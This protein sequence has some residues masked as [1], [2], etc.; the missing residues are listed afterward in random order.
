ME[1]QFDA[2]KYAKEVGDDLIAAFD[3]AGNA[4]TPGLVGSAREHATRQK[5]GHLLP[6]SMA[7]GT[8][9]VIDSYGGV[10]KHM[11]IVLYEKYLCPVYSV[12]D[13]PNTTY[14]PCEGVMAVGEIKS[15]MGSLEMRD[16]FEKITSVKKLR[17]YARPTRIVLDEDLE[18][19]P[20]VTFRSY[21]S[22]DSMSGTE[23]EQFDQEGKT[24]DQIF[25][26][27]LTGRFTLSAATVCEKY[28]E[29][30]RE[31]GRTNSPNLIAALDG[32]QVVRPLRM[33]LDGKKAQ[34]VRG[35][36]EANVICCGTPPGNAFQFLLSTI[37]EAY[38][39]GRTVDEVAFDRYFAS[40]GQLEL[41][42][43]KD[44]IAKLE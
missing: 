33:S 44:G 34:I 29:F 35:A 24:R 13:D 18:M 23:E 26:F 21:G 32:N 38:R 28:V 16:A 10:S 1:K 15:Q 17:R 37:Y 19:E 8:G 20:T 6:G 4:T 14:F 41:N 5:F 31:C 2:P 22:P 9:C 43:R 40:D 42:L 7:V 11:D 12:N 36:C 27:S 30:A 3:K 39:K 25:G